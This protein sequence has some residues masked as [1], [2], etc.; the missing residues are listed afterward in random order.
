MSSP[1]LK[2]I[3][4][5]TLIRAKKGLAIVNRKGEETRQH[6]LDLST[7]AVKT[8]S[9]KWSEGKKNYFKKEYSNNFNSVSTDLAS[10]VNTVYKDRKG[11]TWN[12][13]RR[14]LIANSNTS[15][16]RAAKV[17]REQVYLTGKP[18]TR[19]FIFGFE[20]SEDQ[21]AQFEKGEDTVPREMQFGHTAGPIAQANKLMLMPE[22]TSIFKELNISKTAIREARKLFS[23]AWKLDSI[24]EIQSKYTNINEDFF[25][26]GKVLYGIFEPKSQIGEG[27]QARAK[28][29]KAIN[30][31]LEEITIDTLESALFEAKNSPSPLDVYDYGLQRAFY[32][33][34]DKEKITGPKKSSSKGRRKGS[35][36]FDRKRELIIHKLNTSQNARS[37]ASTLNLQSLIA[38]INA[39]LHG[40]LKED[41][42][43][44]GHAP[45]T[46]NYRTGRFARSAELQDLR[47]SQSGKALEADIT[48]MRHPY[49]VFRPGGR[50]HTHPYRDPE[51]LIGMSIRKIV[52]EALG[53]H[54]TIRTRLR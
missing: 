10:I 27:P 21:R 30:L 41:V 25:V 8:A 33:E 5:E 45:Y 51:R 50:L 49:D 3:I 47:L 48:Y 54:L 11:Y 16:R 38:L 52:T 34:E 19:F 17:I 22:A 46:L 42:M 6:G 26:G 24:M 18:E 39:K 2:N 13:R 20:N 1:T 9:R 36:R 37:Q 32:G 14:L 23:E 53:E 28:F 7:L 29:I 15:I 4:L 43:G 12:Y 40:T 31:L 44:K 35:T